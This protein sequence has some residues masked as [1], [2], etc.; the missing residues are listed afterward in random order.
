METTSTRQRRSS[1]GR[2]RQSLGSTRIKVASSPALSSHSSTRAPSVPPLP[3]LPVTSQQAAIRDPAAGDEGGFQV[4][5]IGHKGVTSPSMSSLKSSLM[6]TVSDDRNGNQNLGVGDVVDVPGG[7]HGIIQF[8]GEVKGKRG[9]FAGVELAKEYAARGKN[10]GDVDGIN[11]FTT[12]VKGAGI[13]LPSNKAY[14]RMAPNLSSGHEAPQTPTSPPLT[15][16]GTESRPSKAITPAS[17]LGFTP[18]LSQ[19]VG[20]GR[21]PSPTARSKRP[22]LPR[23]ESPQ[24]KPTNAGSTPLARPSV[25]KPSL[26]KSMIGGPRHVPSPT[27]NRFGGSVRGAR[28]TPGD[29]S[30]RPPATPKPAIRKPTGSRPLSPSRSPSR[31]EPKLGPEAMFDE[32]SDNTPVSNSSSALLAKLSQKASRP[33]SNQEKELRSLRSQLQER[34]KLLEKYAA[35]LDEMQN[36]VAELQAVTPKHSS[37]TNRSSL[38]SGVEDL[39]TPSLRALV[40]EKNEKI[41]ALTREFDSHRA[42][43]RDTIDILEKTSDETNKHYEDRIAGLELQL[44]STRGHEEEIESVTEQLM[45]LEKHVEELEEGL[46]DSRRGES[47]ARAEV[48]HLRGEVERGKAELRR[49]REKPAAGRGF[50]DGSKDPSSLREIAHRDN[51]INGLKAIIHSLSRDASATSPSS[52]RSSRR[53]K[54]DSHQQP[55]PQVEAQLS[56]ARRI[57]EKLGLENKN[58]EELVDRKTEREDRLEQEIQRLR[59]HSSQ[60]SSAPSNGYSDRTSIPTNNQNHH[61]NQSNHKSNPSKQSWRDRPLA[62]P[63]ASSGGDDRSATTMT[64]DSALWCEICEEHG[65]DI[66]HCT[67]M[68]SN[69]LPLSTQPQTNG[70]SA[71]A[72]P[73][74]NLSARA[75]NAD[76]FPAPLSPSRSPA[77]DSGRNRDREQINSVPA[78]PPPQAEKWRM[79]NPTDNGMVPG[80]ASG[81]VDAGKW[82]ALCERDGHESVDCPFDDDAY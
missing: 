25:G 48:E 80:K 3:A 81:F 74:S 69:P 17:N 55:N 66:L 31:L 58:L 75:H 28:E 41:A 36:S 79:P 32:E 4:S 18:K 34:D 61:Q 67:N 82:C 9:L 26:S 54:H 70:V 20:P 63:P 15:T 71:T 51:E 44:S 60:L 78:N 65:H 11:Y 42:D 2:P 8:I 47:E 22:S 1:L 59:K 43:F 77:P 45:M 6:R 19:S 62:S 73:H 40:R 76:D 72:H 37:A 10:D 14:K 38:A 27:P 57:N 52:P 50:G 68:S 39:D 49:E 56:E 24:R 30:K 5:H 35:D 46:E 23:P 29:P 13:F 33:S 12:S 16:N 53:S 64:E 21:V 7:M